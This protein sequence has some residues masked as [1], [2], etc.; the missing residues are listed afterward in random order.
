MPFRLLLEI[1]LS[2]FGKQ[3]DNNLKDKSMVPP[4]IAGGG[5][6]GGGE[7]KKSLTVCLMTS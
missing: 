7:E 5:S 2:F 6:N 4:F 3:F 1:P